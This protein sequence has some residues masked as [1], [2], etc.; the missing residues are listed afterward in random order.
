MNDLG[1]VKN[2]LGSIWYFC[3]GHN[4]SGTI[5][6]Y[7]HVFDN[8]LYPLIWI[9]RTSLYAA[10]FFTIFHI[11]FCDFYRKETTWNV[12]KEINIFRK[13]YLCPQSVIT[14]NNLHWVKYINCTLFILRFC[15]YRLIKMVIYFIG[16]FKYLL[17]M[18]RI[19]KFP[20]QY[21]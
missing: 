16:F 5:K 15:W 10:S 17:K 1:W 19:L 13:K 4:K 12:L 21:L 14:F 8:G 11:H 9:C 7:I 20:K 18:T 6:K 2:V 3:C